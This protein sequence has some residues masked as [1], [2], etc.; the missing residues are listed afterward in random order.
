MAWTT[1]IFDRVLADVTNQ[2]SKGFFNVVDWVR[3]N[4]NAYYVKVLINVLRGVNVS[5]TALTPPTITTIPTADDLN[6]FIENIETLRIASGI[7][8][9]TELIEL[10]H[11]Y[12]A[13]ASSETPDYADVNDWER[14]LNIIKELILHASYYEIFCGVAEPG[15]ARFWQSRFR[16]PFTLSEDIYYRVARTGVAISGIGM[17]RANKWRK[18]I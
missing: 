14:D 6:D 10:K 12:F 1:A 16:L 13:G 8:L 18:Y 7:P 11:D 4:G 3:I 15:Q 9:S 17:M 2:T 5:I